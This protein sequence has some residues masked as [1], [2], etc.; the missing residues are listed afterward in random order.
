MEL[1]KQQVVDIIKKAPQGSD[2][3]KVIKAL[4]DKGYSLEGYNSS[5]TVSRTLS[6]VEKA[7]EEGVPNYVPEKGVLGKVA[8][9]GA[10]VGRGAVETVENITTKPLGWAIEKV[11]PEGSFGEKF[12]K[13]LQAGTE[14]LFGEAESGAE[15]A[16]RSAGEFITSFAPIVKGAQLGAAAGKM[17]PKAGKIGQFLGSSIGATGASQ[18]TSGEIASKED[19]GT[20]LVIDTVLMGGSK[21]LGEPLVALKDWAVKKLSQPV[22]IALEGLQKAGIRENDLSIF[23][24][25]RS[26]D[27]ETGDLAEKYYKQA[28][29]S[30]VTPA[31]LATQKKTSTAMDLVKDDVSKFYDAVQ[32]KLKS[33]GRAIG[34]ES[35]RL[36]TVPKVST[37]NIYNKVK[38]DLAE[39]YGATIAKDGKVKFGPRLQGMSAEQS[40]IQDLVNFLNPNKKGASLRNPKEILDVVQNAFGRMKKDNLDTQKI[41]S[42]FRSYAKDALEELADS[43]YKKLAKEYVELLDLDETLAKTVKEDAL[44]APDFLRRIAGKSP[45]KTVTIIDEIQEYGKKYG[46]PEVKN[47]FKKAYIAELMDR[48]AGSIPPQSLAGQQREALETGIEAVKNPVLTA[49]NKGIQVLT[50]SPEKREAIEKFLLTKDDPE[51]KPALAPFVKNISEYISNDIKLKEIPYLDKAIRAIFMPD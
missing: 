26:A 4:I 32:A 1:T 45:N 12:G 34:E 19:L 15:E 18:A 24:Q 27:K 44:G 6:T 14:Q 29:E 37:T 23:N 9:F 25:I 35:K 49:V 10:G 7:Q 43:P 20:G 31:N 28:V 46:V 36:K 30:A 33:V 13:N 47:L 8:D 41:A 51:I 11:S 22:D 48:V 5:P 21:L 2:P 38:T 17:I 3:K 42:N 40:L 39:E 50:Q 16:G